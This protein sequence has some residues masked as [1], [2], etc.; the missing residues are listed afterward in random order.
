[1]SSIIQRADLWLIDRMAQ[2]VADFVVDHGG[3][4]CFGLA[5]GCLISVLGVCFAIAVRESDIFP[6]VPLTV[7]FVGG[8]WFLFG[9]IESKYRRNPKF[10]NPD[11]LHFPGRIFFCCWTI[12]WCPSKII[13]WDCLGVL[14]YVLYLS[15]IYFVACTPRPP[16]PK[17]VDIRH[18][19]TQGAGT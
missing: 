14:S 1:M 8:A 4:D 16:K 18:L 11:R 13:A 3:P 17:T 2:P 10:M 12:I 5:R 19:T 6:G 15:A 7:L 9:H